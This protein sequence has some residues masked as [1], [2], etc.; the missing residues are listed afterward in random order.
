MA[1]IL[2]YLYTIILPVSRHLILWKK[3]TD[4]RLAFISHASEDKYFIT[5]LADILEHHGISTWYD[6]DN[7]NPADTLSKKINNALKKANYFIWI[8]SK[9]SE[10]SSRVTDEINIFKKATPNGTIIPIT[11]ENFDLA[12]KGHDEL[13]GLKH[14]GFKPCMKTGFEELLKIFD[15]DYLINS[16]EYLIKQITQRTERI[17]RSIHDRRVNNIPNRIRLDCWNAFSSN[18]A[19]DKF[20]SLSLDTND[21]IEITNALHNKLKKYRFIKKEH[22]PEDCKIAIDTITHEIVEKMRKE[23]NFSA[24]QTING[25]A[26]EISNRFDIAFFDRRK[27]LDRRNQTVEQCTSNHHIQ[28][29]S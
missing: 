7:L 25:I 21:E 15:Q 16:R 2:L 13:K 22:I 5:L 14:I 24:I 10:Q 28:K 12:K 4:N 1:N 29:V 8:V 27:M 6:K 17:Q 11:L 3:M 9:H 19:I 18:K 23:G 20:E 26:D